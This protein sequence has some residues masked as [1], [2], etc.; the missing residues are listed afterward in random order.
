MQ[1]NHYPKF[2]IYGIKGW[3]NDPNGLIY[4]KNQYHVFYQY[5]PYDVK[6]GPMH[7]GHAVSED[8]RHW[9]YLPVA[10]KPDSQDDGCFSGSAIEKDGNLYLIYTSYTNRNGLIRQQQAIA[11]SQD[12]IHFEKKGLIL[13]TESI[14]EGYSKE[15]FRDPSVTKIENDFFM[16]VAGK[17]EDG[18][19]R[20][21]VFKSKDL[22]NWT[23]VYDLFNKDCIGTMIECPDKKDNILIFSELNFPSNIDGNNNIHATRY[24][25]KNENGNF[26]FDEAKCLDYGFDFY[27]PQ[28]FKDK[29]IL[30][31][32]MSMW[33]R[34]YLSAAYG[35]AGQLTYPRKIEVKNNELIQTPFLL[36][37]DKFEKV[38][39]TNTNELKCKTGIIHLTL[40]SLKNLNIK[41]NVNGNKYACLFLDKDNLIFDIKNCEQVSFKET[42]INSLNRIRKMN[43]DLSL[44][45]HQFYFVIDNGSIEIFVDGK[46]MSSLISTKDEEGIVKFNI[47]A[48]IHVLEMMRI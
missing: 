39:L 35:F 4:Y 44:L 20:I 17:K 31:G 26:N 12:G 42:D 38:I 41:F 34:S 27:A 48:N 2:H 16:F 13:T 10:L 46:V 36:D 30:I 11:I 15:D 1:N 40:S 22:F 21:L 45:V 43:I 5:Y 6:W 14:P 32:W 23:F 9:T 29:D 25:I 37:N 24:I 33:D 8:L 28:M 18:K 7:W 19:G 3:I 47:S